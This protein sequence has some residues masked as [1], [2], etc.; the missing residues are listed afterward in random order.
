MIGRFGV[1]GCS[2]NNLLEVRCPVTR[3]LPYPVELAFVSWYQGVSDGVSPAHYVL[4][5]MQ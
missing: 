5:I 4:L 3:L 2:V 1:F